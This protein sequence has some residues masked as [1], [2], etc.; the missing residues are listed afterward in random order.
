MSTC[1]V[2]PAWGRPFVVA[3]YLQVR[4]V[5]VSPTHRR[6]KQSLLIRRDAT[7]RIS[8]PPANGIL[9]HSTCICLPA[10]SP[11]SR[12]LAEGRRFGEGRDIFE[13]PEEN[14]LFSKLPEITARKA[15]HKKPKSGRWKRLPQRDPKPHCPVS[16]SLFPWPPCHCPL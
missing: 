9:Q 7:L 5:A 6:G 2:F 10:R 13:Q 4:L 8:G 15:T 11:A 14:G 16:R 1:V 3:A 12:S